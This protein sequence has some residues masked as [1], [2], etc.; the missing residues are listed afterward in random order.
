MY[1]AAPSFFH[2]HL[3]AKG[4]LFVGQRLP[5]RAITAY[6]YRQRGLKLA[7]PSDLPASL[8]QPVEE[9]RL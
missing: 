6:L 2:S 4:E 8:S 7:D 1:V 5:G 3:S 9:Y